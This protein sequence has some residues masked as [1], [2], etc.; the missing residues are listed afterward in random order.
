MQERTGTMFARPQTAIDPKPPPAHGRSRRSNRARALVAPIALLLA[1]LLAGCA[2]NPFMSAGPPAGSG[3]AT[4]T[5][6]PTAPAP[7]I[8]TAQAMRMGEALRAAGD[9]TGAAVFFRRAHML[10]PDDPAPLLGMADAA[11]ASGRHD[12]AAELYRQTLALDPTNTAAHLGYGRTLLAMGR[13]G[14]ARAELRAA[15]DSDPADPRAALA[16]G[17]AAELDGDPDAARAVYRDALRL[18]P[19][20]VLLRNNLAL[21]L[22]IAGDSG[23]A[24][25]LLD[26]LAGTLEG[27]PRVRQN[28]ALVN[29]LAGHDDQARAIAAQDLDGPALA[30]RLAFFSRLRTLDGTRLAQAV[31]CACLPQDRPDADPAVAENETAPNISEPADPTSPPALLKADNPTLT[32]AEVAWRELPTPRPRPIRPGLVPPKVVEIVNGS[33]TLVVVNDQP[34][35]A[36]TDADRPAERAAEPRRLAAARRPGEP[37]PAKHR[38]PASSVFEAGLFFTEP[39]GEKALRVASAG[40]TDSAVVAR[41]SAEP[42]RIV[43]L[44]DAPLVESDPCSGPDS[45]DPQ[46]FIASKKSALVFELFSLSMRNSIASVTPM[47]INTRRSTHIFDSVP[48]STSSSSLRVPDLVMSIDGQVRLSASLR[49]RMISEL[50]VPLNSSKITSSMRDP[51]S[52][53]AV[54]MMVSEP[55]SSMLRAAP[56]KRLGRWRALASTPPVSTLPEEGTTVL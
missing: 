10:A 42:W 38:R 7:S 52:I 11:A 43:A 25:A 50:P 6:P 8:E 26:E 35:Q 36:T 24:I 2:G 44:D 31:M 41:P 56:K 21:S 29:A 17:V 53:S 54:E 55:P 5:A 1:T 4:L 14:S 22:S 49:S 13:P 33:K 12:D 23:Q 46:L 48:L 3:L 18:N 27:G 28:L 40:E 19:D 45:D 32:L 16:L 34:E 37:R 15:L 9:A 30:E 47:G 51:V 39:E 20:N